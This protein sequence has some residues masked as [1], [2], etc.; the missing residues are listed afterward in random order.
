MLTNK[1]FNS[2]GFEEIAGYWSGIKAALQ[3]Y[4][5]IHVTISKILYSNSVRCCYSYIYMYLH[6]VPFV[7]NHPNKAYRCDM[8]AVNTRATSSTDIGR[9]AKRETAMD[10]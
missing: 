9:Q 10:S 7:R 8:Q 3:K 1:K 2:P 6:V 5:S 4:I